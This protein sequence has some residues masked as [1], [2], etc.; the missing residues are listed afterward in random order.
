MHLR[1]KLNWRVAKLRGLGEPDAHRHSPGLA[2]AGVPV[3]RDR[4]QL[5]RIRNTLEGHASV[6]LRV[7]V[8]LSDLLSAILRRRFAEPREQSFEFAS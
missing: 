3:V 8:S 7:E 2:A 6:L 5:L 4:S 1:R